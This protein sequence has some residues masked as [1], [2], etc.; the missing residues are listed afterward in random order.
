[1]APYAADFKLQVDLADLPALTP[2]AA[3]EFGRH[4][5]RSPVI[6]TLFR[7]RHQITHLRECNSLLIPSCHALPVSGSSRLCMA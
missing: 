2:A 6:S 4:I 3:G 1:M 7:E 5:C